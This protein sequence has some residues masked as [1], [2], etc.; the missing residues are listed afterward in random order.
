MRAACSL[1]VVAAL[2]ASC[3]G[4][5]VEGTAAELIEVVDGD[6]I[7]ARVGGRAEVIRLIGLNT[8][9]RGECHSDAA[10]GALREMLTGTSLRV[11]SAGPEEQDRFGRALRYVY[12][13]DVLVNLAM[14]AAGHGVALAG[15]HPRAADFT[16]ASEAAW[17]SR[18]GMWAPD[19]CGGGS[20]TRPS[21]EIGDVEPDPPGDD[22]QRPNEEVVVV[23][24]RGNGSVDVSGWRLRDES[25]SHRYAFAPGTMLAPDAE[26]AVHS[27]CGADTP[28]DRYWCVGAV[29][30]NR[31]DTVILQ[32]ADGTVVDRLVYR[33]G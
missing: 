7:R 15:D 33:P 3:S 29:W 19:A 28:A 26:I 23:H 18:A 2:L 12:G 24:N 20:A 14:V 27:G 31:G 16:E 21:V 25:S 8:S 5:D 13:D 9:E 10:T 22:G 6:T 32:A 11:E 30:S 17:A 4:P 1:L